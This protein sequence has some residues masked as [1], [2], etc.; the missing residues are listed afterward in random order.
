MSVTE[1]IKS[2]LD[3][4]SYI[5]QYVPLKK[6]GRYYKANCPFHSENTPSFVVNPDTQSWRCFG[7]CAEGGDVFS[8]AMKHHGWDFREALEQLGKATGVEVHKQSPLDRQRAERHDRLRGLLQVAADIYH[9]NLIKKD[10]GRDAF[11]YAR[12][13]RGFSSDTIEEFQIGYA[14]NGWQYILDDLKNLGYETQEIIDAGLAIRNDNDRVYDRFRNRL[15]IPIHDERGRVVGFGARAL[16]PD[17][18]PKYMNSPQT[19]VFDKS[20]VLFGLDK[21]KTII[22]DT[23]TAVIV[24]GYMDVIQAFQ[25]GFTNVVAQMGTA[26]TDTQLN[27]LV[28]RYAKRIVMALD[29]DAA[30]Q[31]A[32]RRSLETARQTLQA[33]YAGRLSVDIR[34][35]HIPDAKDP[36]DL[37]RETPDEWPRLVDKAMPVAQ[38]VIEME[39]AGLS[40]N[41]SIQERE[42]LAKRILPILTASES[43][44]YTRDNIQKLALR[45]RIPERDLLRWADEQP[46]PTKSQAA[47]SKQDDQPPP[48]DIDALEPP[49][50]DTLID[51]VGADE[52]EFRVRLPSRMP[53]HDHALEAR[54]LQGLMENPEVFYQ[55]NRKFRELAGGNLLLRQGPLNDLSSEDFFHGDFVMIMRVFQNALRQH[56][57]E[58]LVFVREHID[59]VLID[60][61]DG[62]ILEA[63]ETVQRQVRGRFGGDLQVVWKHHT[64][65][66][67]VETHVQQELMIKALALR[68]QR[69]RRATDDCRFELMQAQEEGQSQAVEEVEAHIHILTQARQLIEIELADQQERF[70]G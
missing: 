64:R 28:P 21:A 30:G 20:R 54:C 10:I 43:D 25:A 34:V 55:I 3:I 67:A 32:T 44:L 47:P 37:I 36:D 39:A 27:T 29:S 62:L 66:A 38:F 4:V 50:D 6:A 59:P 24:E 1:E 9:E 8:F 69:L 41:A 7:A 70:T 17:D 52:D 46:Q 13:Q 68:Q 35:L 5:Q 33:D 61:L 23:E 31:N 14:A 11:V 19:D 51:D 42:R 58:P 60:V 48:L 26:L 63:G 56:E 22:R 65:Y 49:P 12:Q 15:M 57:V 18:N 2:K 40:E 53:L 16:D 45:L